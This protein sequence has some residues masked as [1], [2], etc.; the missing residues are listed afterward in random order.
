VIYYAKWAELDSTAAT[1]PKLKDKQ[2]DVASINARIGQCLDHSERIIDVVDAELS[3]PRQSDPPKMIRTNRVLVRPDKVEEFR[4]LLK[5]ELLPAVHKA[6]LTTFG[7]A[8]TM[9]GGPRNEFR[10]VS[11]IS[12]WADLDGTSPI[13]KAM[14]QAAYDSFAAKVG[15][16]TLENEYNVYRFMPDLSYLPVVGGAT[17]TLR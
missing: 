6:G 16:L 13:V 3:L 14:G 11:A 12:S 10:G 1:D 15:A 7:I 17:A 4:A 9:Y 2:A 5:A 8:R